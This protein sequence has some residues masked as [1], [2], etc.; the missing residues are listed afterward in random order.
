M[1]PPSG[2]VAASTGSYGRWNTGVFP[3][4]FQR[5]LFIGTSIDHPHK[6]MP[7]LATKRTEKARTAINHLS[8]NAM[9]VSPFVCVAQFAKD[10]LT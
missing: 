7:K 3:T 8:S 4:A 5:L 9:M 6:P 1:G 2:V 10:R